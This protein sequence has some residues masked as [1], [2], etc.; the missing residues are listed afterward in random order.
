ML[1]AAGVDPLRLARRRRTAARDRAD[2]RDELTNAER[3]HDVVVRTELET[4]HAVDLLAARRHDDDRNGRLC[5]DATADVEAVEVGQA[6]VE[7]HDVGGRRGQRLVSRRGPH[8]G[9]AF[10]PQTLGERD[11]DR[12]V[13]FDEQDIH[14]LIVA[15]E[16]P[17]AR[18]FTDS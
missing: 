3:L 15:G 11:R 7:Q 2:A 17:G 10:A 6:Q 9:E 18:N 5:A 1:I 16:A 14:V 12:V 4:D 13:V 8:D